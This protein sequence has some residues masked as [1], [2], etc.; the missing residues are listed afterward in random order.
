[1]TPVAGTVTYSG[2]TATF[3][4]TAVLSTSTLYTATITTG[5]RDPTGTSL[6]TNSVWT[7][8]TAAPASVV[9]T[10]PANG[11]VAVAANTTISATFSESMNPATINVSTFTLTGPGATPLAGNVTYAGTTATFAPTAALAAGTLYTATIT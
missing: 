5:A 3:T 10:A 7:F 8:T 11:A 9:S 2:T 4:P 6:A 1:T